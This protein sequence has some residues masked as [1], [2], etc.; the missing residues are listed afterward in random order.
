MG[1]LPYS[2]SEGLGNRPDIYTSR[3]SPR[4]QSYD[5]VDMGCSI[6]TGG[7]PDT[8]H[9]KRLIEVVCQ[10]PRTCSFEANCKT[11]ITLSSKQEMLTRG[12]SPS[13]VALK[14]HHPPKNLRQL[15]G[16]VDAFEK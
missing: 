5:M 2:Q 12:S 13:S 8:E 14:V 16:V 10:V 6:D 15:W 1:V 11:L 3:T 9:S 7:S 4:A